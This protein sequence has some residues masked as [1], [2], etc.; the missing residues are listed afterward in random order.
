MRARMLAGLL[1]GAL[2]FAPVLVSAQLLTLGD[3]VRQALAQD[4][5]VTAAAAEREAAA[6]GIDVA[7]HAYRPR[8]DALATVNRAT[9]NNIS[10]LLFPQAVISP[11][12][13]P[14]SIDNSPSSVWGTALG[15][16]V[17]WQPIDFGARGAAVDVARAGE[18]RGRAAE[19]TVR[20]D[21]AARAADAY[22][23]VLAA[24]ATLRGAEAAEAR[25][26][27][28]QTVV[29][30]LVRGELRP[31]LDAATAKAER[32]AATMQV[33]QARRAVGAARATLAAVLGAPAASPLVPLPPPPAASDAT[34][35]SAA[36]P[37]LAEWQAAADEAAA[38]EHA[39]R[40]SADP[41]VA[42]QGTVYGRG[43]GVL[44][45]NTSGTGANGL[46]LEAYNWALGLTV[47]VPVLEWLNKG[48]REAVEL[49][50]HKAAEAR[51]QDT[52]REL[53]RRVEV[54]RHERDAAR[55]VATQARVMAEVARQV[56]AQ[57]QARYQAGLTGI[58]E[59]ADAERRLAQADIDLGLADLAI[60][61]AQLILAHA[62][63]DGVETFLRALP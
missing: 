35:V 31:G 13:G 61:R 62:A 40:R 51:R 21:R 46:G 15:A 47:S 50:R 8:L 11:I 19:A 32:A 2:G 16:L 12:S 34:A 60:W 41:V 14:P 27:V 38:R 49:L 29:D 4:E 10:G 20:L 36:H 52:N 43:T 56:A 18:A 55:D 26:G 3:A 7:R 44:D 17:T 39:A 5:A 48:D 25:A 33:V 22:L 54:A 24:E 42:V 28:L 30:A 58:T 6:I 57:A 23:S 45:D 1:G 59:V 9:H 37:A 53:Q 63:A